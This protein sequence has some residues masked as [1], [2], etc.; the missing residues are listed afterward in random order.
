MTLFPKY[1][2]K[3]SITKS[4]MLIAQNKWCEAFQLH[5]KENQEH[6]KEKFKNAMDKYLKLIYPR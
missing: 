3:K 6:S 4:K 2:Q 5:P 1:Y